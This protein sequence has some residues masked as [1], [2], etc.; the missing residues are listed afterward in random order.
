MN[1]PVS[2]DEFLALLARYNEMIWPGQIV[3][4]ALAGLAAGIGLKRSA[5]GNWFVPLMTALLWCWT[6]LFYQIG[7]LRQFTAAA[8]AFGAIF[9]LQGVLL[10]I[11]G[12]RGELRFRFRANVFGIAGTVFI[13][14]AMIAQPLIGMAVGHVYPQAA[15]FGVTPCSLMIFT[16]GILLWVEPPVPRVLLLIPFVGSWISFISALP[17]GMME[18]YPL[19][20][21]GLIG[22]LLILHQERKLTVERLKAAKGKLKAEI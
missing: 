22:S 13:L 12:F 18:D 5:T 6:G 21:A 11:Y 20:V 3:A 1:S 10:L 7:M 8:Y 19:P 4:Y 15:M 2:I 17:F 9:V 16:F 14:Y